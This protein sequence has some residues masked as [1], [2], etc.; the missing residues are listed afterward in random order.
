[1][2]LHKK[3]AIGR[4]FLFSLPLLFASDVPARWPHRERSERTGGANRTFAPGAPEQERKGPDPE[5]ASTEGSP[6]RGLRPPG[7]FLLPT[8]LRL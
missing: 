1:M 3:A 6:Q 2:E 4:L 8:S 5:H 7:L